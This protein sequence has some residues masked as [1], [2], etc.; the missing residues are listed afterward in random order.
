MKKLFFSI[1]I[2]IALPLFS[3]YAQDKQL[4]INEAI[5]GQWRQLSPA[6]ITGLK[7]Q[8]S[9]NYYAWVENFRSL[10]QGS[11]SGDDKTLFTLTE[12]NDALAQKNIEPMR[13]IPYWDYAW[14]SD[15]HIRLNT[16]S[17]FITFDVNAKK[18]DVTIELPKK[19]ENTVFCKE[20]K[21]LAFTQDNNL[22]IASAD[23]K[24]VD[25]TK[26]TDKNIV[27]GQSVSRSEFGID[28]GIFWSPKGNALAFFQKDESNVSDYPLVDYMPRVA[29]PSPTKYPMAGEKSE[30]VTLGVYN[31]ASGK[32][33]FIEN[34]KESEKY[35]TNIS[36]SPDEKFIYIAV[37]NRGQDHMKFNKYDAKSGKFVQ[38]LFEEKHAKYVE[39]EHK[40]IFINDNSNEFLW[41]SE[42]DGYNHLYLYDTDGK[43]KRQLTEGQWVVTNVLGFDAKGKY[44]FIESTE[45]SPI[46]RHI[47]KVEIK[48]G[49]RTKITQEAGTHSV[50]LSN[51]K[52]FAIDKYSDTKTPNNIVITKLKKNKTVKSLLKADNPLVDY[53]LGEAKIGTIKSADGKTDLYYRLITPTNFNPKKKYPAVIYV[54]GGPHTQLI[55]NQWLGGVR[56]WQ[57]YMAQQGYV[58]LTVDNRGSANRGFEFENV[59][60]RKCGEAEMEDQMEGVKLLENLGYVDMDKIGV[61]GWSYGGYMTI[62]LLTKYPDIF[63]VA[64][65]GGPVID[66]KYYEIM[67]GER[68]MDTPQEN[69]EGYSATS[70]LSDEKVKNIGKNQLL[71]VHGGIDPTVVMQHSMSFV[72]KCVENN[73]LIDFFVYPTH[74]HNVR[75]RDRV[76][77][78]DKVSKYFDYYLKR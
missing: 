34:E 57:Q 66:W 35:L 49:K 21:M 32:V 27:S 55:N 67:Y 43:M 26:K 78:M 3:V 17:H 20:N 75:G 65:A 6:D 61:H 29:E 5:I 64:V 50:Q 42:R 24:I 25:V 31:I 56:L 77:L 63:K 62:S 23:G 40:A 58:M 18:V 22:L 60:H 59:I 69:P 70:L 33:F 72:R 1:L 30:H 19:A 15:N 2:F 4:T 14:V 53:D 10:K 11:I 36:W 51:D 54:Y 7:W 52:K 28:G 48:Q 41:Q 13:G 37:L 38:T 45:V 73:Q 47:Y 74:E 46:E 76:H 8:G 9:T 12:L 68:Y 16:A 44:V 71:I 39:P